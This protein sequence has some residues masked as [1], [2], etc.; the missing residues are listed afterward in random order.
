M[1]RQKVKEIRHNKKAK[2]IELY[3]YRKPSQEVCDSLKSQG[4]RFHSGKGCWYQKINQQIVDYVNAN[5]VEAAD[6]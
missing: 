3:F 6:V 4:F 5:F 1:L 2:G